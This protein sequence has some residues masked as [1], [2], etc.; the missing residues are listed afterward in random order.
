VGEAGPAAVVAVT[1]IVV[2]GTGSGTVA[3]AP[4]AA[5]PLAGTASPAQT[6]LLLGDSTATTLGIGLSLDAD[7]YG[8]N[9]IDKGILGCGVAEMPD[10]LVRG[11]EAD[12]APACNPSMPAGG[13]WPVL[14]GGWIV[15]YHPSIVAIL[16]GRWEVS[17]VKWR[18]QWTDILHA[19]F[20]GYVRQQLQQAVDVASTGGAHVDL[21]TAPCYDSGEQSDGAPWPE[22]DSD[23]LDA[24]N[25]LVRKVA[26]ANP[27]QA[28]LVDLDGVVC[29]GGRFASAIAGVTVR[30]PDGVHFPY[31]SDTSPQTADPDSEAQV[32]RFSA[33]IGSRLWRSILA[34]GGKSAGAR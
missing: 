15:R 6:V 12:V 33:W 32:E 20:A 22:D 8:A 13:K 10:V 27:Q 14:W 29:P 9:L 7:R 1:V 18:G 30:A 25:D 34:D 28:S 17:T 23:R 31:F 16:A 5:P 21:F 11:V 26:A 4:Q 3:T 24:Y 19:A 2:V